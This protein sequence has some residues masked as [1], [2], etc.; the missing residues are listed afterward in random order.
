LD[1]FAG[2]DALVELVVID[3]DG[4]NEGVEMGDEG[5]VINFKINNYGV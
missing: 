2:P 1:T 4:V 3:W 5:E